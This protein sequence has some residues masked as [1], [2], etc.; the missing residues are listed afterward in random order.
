MGAGKPEQGQAPGW[1]DA[2]KSNGAVRRTS[3]QR[4]AMC[5]GCQVCT[6]ALGPELCA[7]LA[8]IYGAVREGWDSW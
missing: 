7:L 4:Y 2:A 6:E 8:L 3:P 1:A 5:L